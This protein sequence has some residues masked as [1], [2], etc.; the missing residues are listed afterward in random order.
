MLATLL[1]SLQ[2]GGY[3][4]TSLD[5]KIIN[6]KIFSLIPVIKIKAA[7]KLQELNKSMVTDN[8]PGLN[9]SQPAFHLF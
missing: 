7:P 9:I 4:T 2:E 6:N 3:V 1:R 8:K 5:S